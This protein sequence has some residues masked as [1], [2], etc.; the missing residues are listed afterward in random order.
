MTMFWVWCLVIALGLVAMVRWIGSRLPK[1]HTAASRI[2]LAVPP[3]DVWRVITDFRAHPDWRPGLERVEL[4]PD[5]DG[6]PSWYEVC[7]R[8]TRV[9]FRVVESDPPSRLVTRL[10]GEGLPLTGTWVYE[11]TALGEGE[12]ELVIT[13]QDRIYSPLLRV[14]TSFL[15]AYH[16]IMDVFLIALGRAFGEDVRP[17]HLSLRQDGTAGES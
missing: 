6:L 8:R 1:T 11:L 13:E 12:T 3:N 7:A 4:G 10:V 5:I 17:E 14:A 15:C 2:R 9:H 16:G